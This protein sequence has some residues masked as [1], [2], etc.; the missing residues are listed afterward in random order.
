M[1][2]ALTASSL[3]HRLY[4]DLCPHFFFLGHSLGSQFLL[5]DCVILVSSLEEILSFPTFEMLPLQF[6]LTPRHVSSKKSFSCCCCCF[7]FCNPMNQLTSYLFPI[8]LT[9]I[10]TR[11]SINVFFTFTVYLFH[12]IY[13]TDIF[14][15]V[16][17]V[18][19]LYHA[20]YM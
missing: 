4:F 17:C 1:F 3:H 18:K 6:G 7:L 12:K 9:S 10:N 13:L 14:G 20:F 16:K 2:A 19:C 15:A 8:P 11:E 5:S